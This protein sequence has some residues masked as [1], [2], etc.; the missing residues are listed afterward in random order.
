M[1]IIVSL[2]IVTQ[3]LSAQACISHTQVV[4]QGIEFE[5]DIVFFIT[6]Q[7]SVV[8]QHLSYIEGRPYFNFSLCSKE[9]VHSGFNTKDAFEYDISKHCKMLGQWLPIHSPYGEDVVK[10]LFLPAFSNRMEEKLSSL[11]MR[12]LV[13]PLIDSAKR[14]LQNYDD[15]FLLAI[16]TIAY[17]Q[18]YRLA[19]LTQITPRAGSARSAR[20]QGRLSALGI[21]FATF[22]LAADLV[23]NQEKKDIHLTKLQEVADT[24]ARLESQMKELVKEYPSHRDT[25]YNTHPGIISFILEA[26][27]YG[28]VVLE[29]EHQWIC[30]PIQVEPGTPTA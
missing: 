4:E 5:S 24:L 29:T 23:S 27:I 15:L 13:A 14:T 28:L 2:F 8:Q 20:M 12:S 1:R 9:Q 10:N 17:S 18:A 19:P 30:E 11:Q 22:G 21:L 25:A 7:H 6:N 26:L 16:S 3:F